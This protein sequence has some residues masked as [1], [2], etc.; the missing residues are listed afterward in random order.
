M[1][2]SVDEQVSLMRAWG[3]IP[4]A[5]V[6]TIASVLWEC[7][8]Y[9]YPYHGKAWVMIREPGDPTT[10]RTVEATLVHPESAKCFCGVAGEF[11]FRERPELQARRRREVAIWE[12]TNLSFSACHLHPAAK[13]FCEVAGEFRDRPDDGS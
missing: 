11:Y 4:H 12:R 8:S 5:L 3:R 2:L 7:I 10:L 9:P 1:G 6:K 13:C